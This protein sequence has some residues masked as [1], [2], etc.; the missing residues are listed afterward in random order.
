MQTL[1]YF[2]FCGT[3]DQTQD[4]FASQA[5][6]C[7]TELLYSQPTYFFVQCSTYFFPTL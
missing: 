4:P 5:G 3:E 7:A 1:F 2:I 6:A